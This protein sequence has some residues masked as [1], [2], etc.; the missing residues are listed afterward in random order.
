M[1]KR[2][3]ESYL[4]LARWLLAP[5]SVMLTLALF[6]LMVNAGRHLFSILLSIGSNTED[7]IILELLR[8]VDLTLTGA[9]VVIVTISVYENFV[10]GVSDANRTGWPEWMGGIDFSQLKLNLLSTIVAISA[11]KLLEIFMDVPKFEERDLTFYVVIH[12]TFVASTVL[13]ALSQWMTGGSSRSALREE[14]K[15]PDDG[16]P[17]AG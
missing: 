1:F 2:L 8:L 17:G 6:A 11:I 15:P 9:L 3:F 7:R 16:P 13:F 12:L 4:F 5:F 14:A 10:S